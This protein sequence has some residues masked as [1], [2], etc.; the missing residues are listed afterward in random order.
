MNF[1]SGLLI[2]MFIAVII[3]GCKSNSTMTNDSHEQIKFSTDTLDFGSVVIGVTK[4][5][6][7]NISNIGS[8]VVK[9][10]SISPNSVSSPYSVTGAPLTIT[11]NYQGSIT[12]NLNA[13][14]T[15]AYFEQFNVTTDDGSIF[16]FYAKNTGTG[17]AG[18]D[19]VIYS[20]VVVGCNR[21]SK[22]DFNPSTD[23][24][25]A[26][27]AQINRTLSEI[28]AVIPKPDF[29]FAAGDIVLGES[30][31]ITL[32]KQ[33]IGW[34]ALYES[35]PA[36]AAGIE[37]V[38][39]PGN[40]ETEDANS[41]PQT[42]GEQAWLNIMSPYITRGGNGP[43]PHAGDPDNLK[44]D[45]SKLTYS[46]NFKDAHFVVISTDPA[47]LDSRPPGNW[48]AADINAAHANSSIKHIFAIGH[49]PAYSYDGAA[50]DGLGVNQANRDM[51]WGALDNANAEGMLSAHNHTYKAFRP[52]NKAWMII[53]GNGG[54]S[55]ETS[56]P[57]FYGFTLIQ[58][59]NS[60]TVIEKS[61]G[62]DFG[63]SYIDPSPIATYPTTLRDSNVISWK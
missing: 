40:H 34:K 42:F 26:N 62:R 57:R 7:L 44:S 60:G 52:T 10:Q 19:S 9:I 39:L 17:N 48:I 58:V 41:T 33:L 59:M 27:L 8:M 6:V 4:S 13:T 30:D 1:K 50:S 24:S 53:A 11:Q 22:G 25:S 54:S 18:V 51:I 12:V 31:S 45:Q 29:F 3:A 49:K 15:G 35:S 38:A 5:I 21:I 63:A 16:H 2:T 55:L 37:L 56:A 46:F 20:F 61:Y 47:G 23:P 28:A 14:M 43:V 36:K 32:A